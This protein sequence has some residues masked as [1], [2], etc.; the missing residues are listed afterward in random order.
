MRL[1]KSQMMA[2]INFEAKAKETLTRFGKELE[3]MF[4]ESHRLENE[5]KRQLGRVK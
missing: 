4:A 1:A 5:I 3:E 2:D